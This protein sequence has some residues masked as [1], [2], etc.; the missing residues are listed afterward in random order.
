M[1]ENWWNRNTD[2]LLLY[3][4]VL[5]GG[6]FLI[7]ILHHGTTDEKLMSWLENSFSTVLGALI[8]ILTG[9]KADSGGS[10]AA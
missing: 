6:L 10:G 7:H 4:L 2:K 3:S 9:R 1:R 8:L 5:L